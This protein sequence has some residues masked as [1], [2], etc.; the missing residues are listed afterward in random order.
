MFLWWTG[1]KQLPVGWGVL[2]H[3]LCSPDIAPLEVLFSLYKILFMEKCFNF[4]EYWKDTC[5]SSFLKKI[6]LG[7]IELWICLKN[8]RRCWNKILNTLFNKI[9]GENGEKSV[10]YFYLKIKGNFWPTQYTLIIFS[11]MPSKI[12]PSIKWFNSI[13]I[14][15]QL[16][17]S[18]DLTF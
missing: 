15:L 1:K 8:G 13:E 9:I 6:S 2:I 11:Y 12:V 14:S 16:V 10:F 18:M 3:P 17:M 4:L 5:N 7:K